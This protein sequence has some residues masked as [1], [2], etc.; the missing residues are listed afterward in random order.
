MEYEQSNIRI[1][2]K[3]VSITNCLDKILLRLYDIKSEE[4]NMN[5]MN[6]TRSPSYNDL[7]DI[8]FAVWKK[9]GRKGRKPTK[10]VIERARRNWNNHIRSSDIGMMP[11]N[12]VTKDRAALFIAG[13]DLGH[14]ARGKLLQ[15]LRRCS[16]RAVEAGHIRFDPFKN[17]RVA[18]ER[19]TEDKIKFFHPTEEYPK[20]L[21]NARDDEAKELFGFSMG[22]GARPAEA[23][24]FCWEDVDLQNGFLTFRYGGSEDGAT[25]SGKPVKVPL[26]PEA[27]HWLEH[28]I[29]RLHNGMKPKSGLLF[30]SPITGK[31]YSRSPDFGLEQAIL[32]A[33]LEKNG[34]SLYAFRHGFCVALAN[35]FFGED[36]APR[37]IARELMRQDDQKVIDV[38]YKILTPTLTKKAANAVAITSKMEQTPSDV[39]V[40]QSKE[41]DPRKVAFMQPGRNSCVSPMILGQFEQTRRLERPRIEALRS[42]AAELRHQADALDALAD[43][44]LN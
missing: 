2:E 3:L 43:D 1:E 30:P 12:H 21:A 8:E 33:G 28:R 32:D 11:V 13:L 7:F 34:R 29:T 23:K 24:A 26:L 44:L 17:V 16:E 4:S 36:L 19:S 40:K 10:G 39:I 20:I 35:G 22:S 31:A 18:R 37:R 6:N 5:E 14:D 25:K 27:R 38:Y 9:T 41:P 15:W 42:S